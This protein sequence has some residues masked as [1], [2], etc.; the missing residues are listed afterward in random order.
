[1]VRLFVLKLVIDDVVEVNQGDQLTCVRGRKV[2][3][4][5]ACIR[6]VL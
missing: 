5:V 4:K 3:L 6:L 2:Q 1:M